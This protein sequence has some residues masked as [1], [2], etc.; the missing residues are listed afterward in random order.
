MKLDF[1]NLGLSA[2][3]FE[4]PQGTESNLIL[5]RVDLPLSRPALP[6]KISVFITFGLWHIHCPR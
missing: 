1:A 3:N 6:T 5:P 4:P 2:F